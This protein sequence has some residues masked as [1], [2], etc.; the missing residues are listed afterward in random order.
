MV[1]S[2]DFEQA[3]KRAS[4][5]RSERHALGWE[6]GVPASDIRLRRAPSDPG[7]LHAPSAWW[8]LWS[9]CTDRYPVGNLLG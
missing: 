5:E 2:L 3:I 1:P 7:A 4:A 6:P 9:A 8:K